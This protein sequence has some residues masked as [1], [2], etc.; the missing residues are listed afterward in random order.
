MPRPK[1]VEVD[2]AGL[3]AVV[4]DEFADR[5]RLRVERLVESMLDDLDW[6]MQYATP[7]NRLALTRGLLPHLLKGKEEQADVAEELRIEMGE[8][9]SELRSGL[10]GAQ[11]DPVVQADSPVDSPG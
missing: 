7:A 4:G 8:M 10:A 6:Q 5:L 3:V 9:M 11:F 2:L 1:K